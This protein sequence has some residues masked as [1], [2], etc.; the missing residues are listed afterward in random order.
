[1]G[2]F[3]L[4]PKCQYWDGEKHRLTGYGCMFDWNK[5]RSDRKKKIYNPHPCDEQH[6]RGEAIAKR[7]Q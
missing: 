7:F 2:V 5:F 4:H 6:V 1:M 3:C